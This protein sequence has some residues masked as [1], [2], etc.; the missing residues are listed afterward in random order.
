[1]PPGGP[2]YTFSTLLDTGAQI[3]GISRTVI[4]TLR[5]TPVGTIPIVHTNRTRQHHDAF[6]L[7]VGIPGLPHARGAAYVVH[8]EPSSPDYDVILGMDI[9]AYY[10]ITI[11]GGVCTIASPMPAH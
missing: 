11:S 6:W 10:D 5:I 7:R 1:M 9:L 3:T 2:Q 4:E 8:L